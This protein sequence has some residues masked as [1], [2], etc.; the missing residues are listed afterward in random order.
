MKMLS[1]GQIIR[2]SAI[3]IN[4][5]WIILPGSL[6]GFEITPYAEWSACDAAV[7][8]DKILREDLL[9]DGIYFPVNN[10]KLCRR[11]EASPI[12]AG[13]MIRSKIWKGELEAGYAYTHSGLMEDSYFFK[14]D[15]LIPGIAEFSGDYFR[16]QNASVMY[17]FKVSRYPIRI[18]AGADYKEGKFRYTGMYTH[19]DQDG[20][21]VLNPVHKLEVTWSGPGIMAGADYEFIRDFY[22]ELLWVN[23]PGLNGHYEMFQRTFTVSNRLRSI[24]QHDQQGKYQKS[25]ESIT[26]SLIYRKRTGGFYGSAGVTN[27]KITEKRTAPV[28]LPVIFQDERNY[29]SAELNFSLDTNEIITDMVVFSTRRP[30]IY[31][32]IFIRLGWSASVS[33]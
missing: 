33:L 25:E 21:Y 11:S 8:E 2:L 6:F 9:T 18:S 12:A 13:A 28:Y 22:A 30:I 4:T 16:Q 31:N 26:L 3:F 32:D 14:M 27:R 5:A 17:R 20:D 19:V 10:S 29:Y 24:E 23:N 1:F 7:S 15:S